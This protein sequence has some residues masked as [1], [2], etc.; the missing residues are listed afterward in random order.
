MELS[1]RDR[2]VIATIEGLRER[3]H[4][5]TAAAVAVSL[6]ISR[7]YMSDVMHDMIE[8]GVL[9]F[10]PE[11]PG[12]LRV[13]DALRAELFPAEAAVVRHVCDEPGC[14]WP[15]KAALDGH[16]RKHKS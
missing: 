16:S 8:R 6:K 11:M 10:E 14:D 3:H 4:A 13:N 15:N 12:S 7:A 1:P 2:Q 9:T 5:C